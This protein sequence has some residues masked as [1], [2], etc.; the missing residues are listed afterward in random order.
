SISALEAINGHEADDT[1]TQLIQHSEPDAVRFAASQALANHGNRAALP[2]LVSLLESEEPLMR[3]KSVRV[4]RAT[5]G[6]NFEFLPFEDPTKRSIKALAWKRWLEEDSST[7]QLRFPLK[8][9]VST[10]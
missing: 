1:L 5:T 3:T 2:A 4:L 7:A 6:Q 8:D 10:F 9:I